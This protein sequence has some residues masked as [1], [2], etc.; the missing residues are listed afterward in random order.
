MPEAISKRLVREVPD[1]VVDVFSELIA[2]DSKKTKKIFTTELLEE[3]K[4]W[5]MF[6]YFFY[7]ILLI[8]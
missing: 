7:L 4:N 5:I 1:N 8:I 2:K 3:L 6:N